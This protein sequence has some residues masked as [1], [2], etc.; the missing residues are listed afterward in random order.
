ME[1]MTDLGFPV[2]DADNHY[3]E[4]LDAFTRHLPKEYARRGVF[5]IEMNGK[6]RLMAGKQLW[7]FI[8]NP[9]FDPIAQ[10]GS[11]DAYFR[12][13]NPK[14]QDVREAFGNLDALADHPEYQNRDARIAVMDEQGVEATIM[15]PT[16]GVGAEEALRHDVDALYAVFHAFNLWVDEDWGYN[17][18]DRI[19]SA[20]MISLLDERKALEELDFVLERGARVICLRAGPLLTASGGRSPADPIYDPFYAKVAEAGAVV[21][22]HSGDAGY[23]RYATD[24]GASQEMEAF[25]ADPFKRMLLNNRPIYDTVSA[26]LAHGLFH[27]HPTLKVATIESGSSWLPEV[28]KALKKTHSQIPQLFPGDPFEQLHRNLW[29]SPFFE[30]DIRGLADLIGVDKILMG[31]DWPHA[32]GLPA[33]TD[34]IKDL[35]GFSDDEIRKIM[36]EN[37]RALI[38][39][40]ARVPA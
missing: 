17:H 29:V 20:A 22:I 14:G 6:P 40:P 28:V 38:G 4:A 27:R 8:P 10:P 13:I 33:P 3:Y 36:Y 15:F 34:Y 23:D 16:L 26:F 35:D 18:L 12:G 30:D 31:S 37:A 7:R 19:Y 9:T 5:W 21:G 39:S 1:P 2:F 32:E 24:W 11:L 25:R